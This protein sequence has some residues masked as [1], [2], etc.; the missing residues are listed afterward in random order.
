MAKR[1][2][3][4]KSKKKPASTEADVSVSSVTPVRKTVRPRAS[5]KVTKAVEVSASAISHE[6][7]AERAYFI[8][9][10]GTGGSEYDNWCRAETELRREQGV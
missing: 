3:T 10:S 6:K 4:S 1:I 5:E 7:I 8:A 2:T 9:L